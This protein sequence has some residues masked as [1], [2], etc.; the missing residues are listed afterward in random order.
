[1]T[2]RTARGRQ[3]AWTAGTK[4][5]S[6]RRLDDRRAVGEALSKAAAFNAYAMAHLDATFFPQA[7]FYQ[8][9]S[10]QA[11]AILMHSKAGLGAATHVW[12]D[13]KLA[14]ALVE[15]HPPVGSSLLTCQPEHVDIMLE[16]LNLWRPQTMLRMSVDSESFVP[17][18][19]RGPVRR[20]L[21]ADSAELNRLYALEGDGIIYSGHHIR[22]GVYFGALNRGRLVAAAGTHIYSKSAGV[23]VVGNV[24]THPDFRGHGLATAVTAAVTAELLQYCRLVV[25]SVDPANRSARYVYD[26]LGY[27]EEGR[28]VESM[29]TRRSKLSPLPAIRRFLASRRA[30]EKGVELVRL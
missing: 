15:L 3:L 5:A 14:G 26:K 12:G 6:I 29:S 8:A 9:Q 21:A 19:V 17:P 22:D 27:R 25:L 24:F 11:S 7:S 4:E 30:G 13:T 16:A 20:L 2:A 23:A 28:M 18:S 10:G 1:M